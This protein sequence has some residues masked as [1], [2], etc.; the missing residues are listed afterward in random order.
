MA[1]KTGEKGV[2]GFLSNSCARLNNEG[3]KEVYGCTIS[4][5]K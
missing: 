3:S 1:I 5:L 2:S 4:C